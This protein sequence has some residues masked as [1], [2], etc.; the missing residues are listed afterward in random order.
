M[1]LS[2]PTRRIETISQNEFENSDGKMKKALREGF[3]Y[4]GG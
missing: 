3:F 2:D 1:L 4:L